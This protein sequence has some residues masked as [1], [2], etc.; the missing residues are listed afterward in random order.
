MAWVT[1]IATVT[2]LEW[3]YHRA[4]QVLVEILVMT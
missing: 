4:S 2:D 1:E 3:A